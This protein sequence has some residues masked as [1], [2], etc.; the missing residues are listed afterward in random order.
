MTDFEE[1]AAQYLAAKQFLLVAEDDA[2]IVEKKL[3]SLR[4][5][6]EQASAEMLRLVD[7]EQADNLARV[8][9]NAEKAPKPKR[10]TRISNLQEQIAT[11]DLALPIQEGKVRDA[12]NRVSQVRDDVA[13]AVLPSFLAQKSVAFERCAEP[14]KHLIDA[15]VDVAAMDALQEQFSGASGSLR[16]T[17]Q[18]ARQKL[19]S[20]RVILDRFKKSLPPRFAELAADELASTESRIAAKAKLFTE[21]LGV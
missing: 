18:V 4:Y 16:L 8:L 19:F 15:L 12:R 3:V 10:L 2:R 6:R 20:A 17:N 11:I 21:Q 5:E 14:L 1:I 13:A 7:L 9:D